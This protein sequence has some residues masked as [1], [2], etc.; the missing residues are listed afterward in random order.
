M[1]VQV[2]IGGNRDEPGI[3]AAQKFASNGS[4]Q[5]LDLGLVLPLV[6]FRDQQVDVVEVADQAVQRL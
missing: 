5:D 6:A 3:V 4:P 2:R 1:D